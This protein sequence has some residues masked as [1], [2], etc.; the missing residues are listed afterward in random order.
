[1]DG[2]SGF[3]PLARTA[4]IDVRPPT[5]PLNLRLSWLAAVVSSETVLAQDDS[6]SR[7][8][9]SLGEGGG[10]EEEEKEQNLGEQ[11]SRQV[12]GPEH[13][14]MCEAACLASPLFQVSAC[15]SAADP[16]KTSTGKSVWQSVPVKYIRPHA[17]WR[18]SSACGPGCV[19]LQRMV[20]TVAS[21]HEPP[22]L[23]PTR[24]N[25]DTYLTKQCNP[26]AI[27]WRYTGI[28]QPCWVPML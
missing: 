24:A 22:R 28:P 15:L 19:R 13:G 7:F 8:R 3:C 16:I 2:S 9:L 11:E 6:T 27:Q 23:A 18:F 20:Y 4:N 5:H 25:R 17:R 21:T 1:M 10:R 26:G 14:I 12:P